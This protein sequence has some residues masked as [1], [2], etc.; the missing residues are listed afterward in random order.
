VADG[1]KRRSAVADNDW[2]ITA[3]GSQKRTIAGRGAGF[4]NEHTEAPSSEN[5]ETRGLETREVPS[6]RHNDHRSSAAVSARPGGIGQ[7][8]G[9]VTAGTGAWSY[10]PHRPR[11]GAASHRLQVG[12]PGRIVGQRTAARID[13][14]HWLVKGGP[15]SL[16]GCRVPGW[17]REAHHIGEG[18]GIVVSYLPDEVG[19]L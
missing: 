2:H 15:P 9:P 11:I 6:V 8:P 5:S 14:R 12:G 1:R 16:L 10:L 4:G 19:H 13:R 7:T 17:N 3:K 18:A